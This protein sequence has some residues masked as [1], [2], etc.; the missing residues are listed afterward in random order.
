M[1]G[2]ALAGLLMTLTRFLGGYVAVVLFYSIS[3]VL[4]WMM[5][6]SP[7]ERG[8]APRP[9]GLGNLMIGIRYV[10]RHPILLATVLITV[11]MNMLLFPYFAIAQVVARDVLHVG[12]G[13]MG[14]LLAG[15]GLGSL[16][17]AFVIASAINIRYHGRL[18]MSGSFPSACRPPAVRPVRVIPP[19]AADTSGAGPRC[20]WVQHDASFDC[21]ACGTARV[22]R[23]GVGGY[24]S[25]HRST[26]VGSPSGR[27]RSGHDYSRFRT[28]A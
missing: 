4:V 13:L 20:C 10:R 22:A 15:D 24:R 9:G 23:N 2:A 3:L 12:A 18:F 14:L 21:D 5:K 1:A 26:P 16:V 8:H 11:V 19:V 27:R 7:T 6:L 25:C 17:G 28:G